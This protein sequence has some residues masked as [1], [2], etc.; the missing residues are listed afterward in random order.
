MDVLETSE[1]SVA[2]W[3]SAGRHPRDCAHESCADEAVQ[4][5]V[6]GLYNEL[7]A[8]RRR[9]AAWREPRMYRVGISSARAL[10][11]FKAL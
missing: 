4:F 7:S 10:R 3:I 2:P 9:G 6:K 11:K 8:R 1:K 5:E